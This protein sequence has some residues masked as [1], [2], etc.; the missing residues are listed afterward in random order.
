MGNL[1]T[2]AVILTLGFFTGGSVFLGD[3]GPLDLVFDGMGVLFLARGGLSL[4]SG[5]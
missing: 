5:Q 2:G 4:M 3:P 1:I